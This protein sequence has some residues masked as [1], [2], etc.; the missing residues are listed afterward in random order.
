[1]LPHNLQNYS[2]NNN[3]FI[4]FAKKYYKYFLANNQK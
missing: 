3:Y 1:M 2:L 4:S